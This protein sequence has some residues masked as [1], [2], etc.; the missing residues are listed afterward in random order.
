MSIKVRVWKNKNIVTI[1]TV[2]KKDRPGDIEGVSEELFVEREFSS[3]WSS[4]SS[5]ELGPWNK[6]EGTLVTDTMEF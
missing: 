2:L 1:L 3:V 4:F 5:T 6:D